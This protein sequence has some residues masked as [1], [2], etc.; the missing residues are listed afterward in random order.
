MLCG[1]T[2]PLSNGLRFV[3]A[4]KKQI[5]AMDLHSK[6]LVQNVEL[7]RGIS[8]L[9]HHNNILCSGTEDGYLE[10]RDS[11]SLRVQ[12]AMLA[13][14]HGVKQI[15]IS[16]N[17][18]ITCGKAIEAS[19]KG[20]KNDSMIKVFDIRTNKLLQP[21]IFSA[22]AAC[23]KVF[24]YL[25]LNLTQ[26]VSPNNSVLAIASSN[27]FVRLMDVEM[28]SLHLPSFQCNQMIS[29]IGIGDSGSI[30]LSDPNGYISLWSTR[31]AI[32]HSEM[33]IPE[34]ASPF[35]LIS[36]ELHADEETPFN[37]LLVPP[38][39]RVDP[40]Q[41]ESRVTFRFKPT[42]PFP[43]LDMNFFGNAKFDDGIAIISKP[44]GFSG[45]LLSYFFIL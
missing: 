39:D 36:S 12:H 18:L 35:S 10:I 42:S 6:R 33:V 27:G 30:M 4:G 8:V 41:L 45:Y 32:I 28:K 29:S 31:D 44:D 24:V 2:L 26:L 3:A 43:L 14:T 11:R 9:A 7:S 40:T 19:S 34:S 20:I 38:I 21:L 37:N 16:D 22:G 13:H 5:F 17:L 15:E 23:I 1:T 25:I